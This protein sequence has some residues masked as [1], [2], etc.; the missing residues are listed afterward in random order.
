MTG[1]FV[2]E[3]IVVWLCFVL[4][5]D[6]ISRVVSN[7]NSNTKNYTLYINDEELQLFSESY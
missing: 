3:T 5:P 2:D 6:R 7:I 4:H 1:S